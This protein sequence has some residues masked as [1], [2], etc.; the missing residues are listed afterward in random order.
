[1]VH[2]PHQIQPQYGGPAAL[3]HDAQA[4][5]K[6]KQ[7]GRRPLGADAIARIIDGGKSTLG[8]RQQPIDLQRLRDYAQEALAARQ[9]LK[10]SQKRL[11]KRSIGHK[12]IAALASVIGNATACVL[13]TYLGDPGNYH[14]A[15]AYVKA[16]G[17][18]LVE[19]SSGM[20]Q[21][22]LK[23]S[24][25]GSSVVRYWLYL[26]ALRL[27]KKN[28]PVRP[29]Y[30]RKRQRDGEHA[31][32]ALVAIM[33]RVGLALYHTAALGEAFDAKR[34]FPKRKHKGGA[35]QATA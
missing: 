17:L 25:R 14:C 15:A 27:I 21:G 7:W 16:M 10:T 28:S 24:K 2:Q 6:L 13:F 4:A 34:L 12:P 31:G 3:A 33:R 19:R 23:I 18:N 8:V 32:R 1:V 9:P 20:Y 35:R 29:W 22:K 11:K 5:A 30:L 26:A